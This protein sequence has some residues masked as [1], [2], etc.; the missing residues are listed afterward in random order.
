VLKQLSYLASVLVLLGAG[1]Q[2]SQAAMSGFGSGLFTNVSGC[3]SSVSPPNCSITD[4]ESQAQ[5]GSDST[6]T[7]DD[8]SFHLSTT[9]ATNVVLGELT[10]FDASSSSKAPFDLNYFLSM[11]FL[12]PHAALS[13]FTTA[14]QIDNANSDGDDVFSLSDLTNLEARLNSLLNPLGTE[15]SDLHYAVDGSSI[16]SGS[17]WSN[18]DG[19]TS[20]LFIEADFSAVPEPAS[21][22]LMGAG[23][24]G[25]AWVRRRIG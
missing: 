19:T 10:W 25:L 14:L 11:S 20:D 24:F 21:L 22:A 9:P 4:G 18:A 17:N 7:A 3:A 15:V 23:L 12:A 2:N 16:L 5:W 13:P 6:L 1:T 8:S